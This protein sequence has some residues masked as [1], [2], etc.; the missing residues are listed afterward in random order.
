VL[1]LALLLGACGDDDAPVDASIPADAGVDAGPDECADFVVPARPDTSACAD[2][3]PDADPTALVACAYGSGHA[4][5]WSIDGAGLPAYDFAI[6]ERCD[7]AGRA[8]SPRPR[9]QRD[10]VHL[11]GNGR[12]LM[13]MARASGAV[14]LYSQDRGHKWFN[15]LD[16]WRDPMTPS[17]P[18]QLGGGFSYLALPD[19]TV[20][21]TRFEDLPLGRATTLQTRRFGVG[22]VE[23]VTMLGALRVTR[24]VLAPDADA[25][26]LVAELRVENTGGSE[27]AVGLVELWD[28]NRDD[29]SVELATSD[30]LARTITDGLERRRRAYTA[31]Y[32]ESLSYDAAARVAV[33]RATAK[34]LP[35]GIDDRLDP[36]PR[37]WFPDPLYLAALDEGVTPDAVW[38]DDRELWDGDDRSP[39]AR[40]ATAGDAATRTLALDGNGQH[41]VLA[42][43]VPLTVAGGAT[44]VRR[45]AFGY[46]PGGGTPDA[47][48]TELRARA[49]TLAADTDASWRS[50]L[51]YAS[52]PGLPHAGAVQ[53]ELAWAAYNTLAS[54][55][56]DEVHQ[57][58]V[59]G[60]G[61]AYRYIHGLDGAMGDL[62]LFADAI[63]L[64]D[65]ALA[66]D[67]LVY[68]MST[69]QAGATA[70]PWRFPYAT[71]GVGSYSDVGIYDQRTD[72]YWL[73][74]SGLG[75]YVGL[76]RDR[77]VLDRVVPYWPSALGE[78][79]DVV[80]HVAHGL[81]WAE[82]LGYGARGLVALGTNDYA[83]GVASL[84]TERATP[85]GTSSTYNAGFIVNGFPLAADV[86]EA[87]DAA[88]ATRLRSIEAGQRAI[89]GGDAWLGSFYARGF[90]DSGN[91]LAPG[92]L[93]LEPQML[94]ILGGIADGARAD[95]LLALTADKL[96]T[97][98]GAMSTVALDPIDPV[99]GPDQPQIAGVWPVANAWTTEAYAQRDAAAGW[100]SFTRNTLFTHAALYPGLWYGVWTGP[101]SFFGPDAARPGEADA[102]KATALT[103]Y[104]A[105]NAH[106]HTSPLRALVGLLGIRGTRD[107]IAIAPHLPTETFHV[108]FP[109]LSLRSTPTR[110]DGTYTPVGAGDVVLR[111]RLTTALAAAAALR[112]Q[113]DGADVACARDG[114]DVV[115]TAL[116]AAETRLVWSVE[117]AP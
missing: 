42:M 72:A 41:G 116:A 24:R 37:D 40:A 12:G 56:Y 77:A 27:S 94:A 91:P 101:D 22:Y 87:R 83:D 48:V 53:R 93:F 23:T 85:A 81:D 113:V 5:A 21:S 62:C 90:V 108:V 9:V 30:L 79:G 7:P 45:F 98:L 74:P 46:V 19:G 51:V 106:M 100:D 32:T 57:T 33:L 8:Y 95:A 16:T 73:L 112:V 36:S 115:F 68:V 99:G 20:G 4:G 44:V 60:Q 54:A 67:T 49:S 11:I 47:A 50:R 80:E 29:L 2:L 13:A 65:P 69:Q 107:G 17:F 86:L 88:L 38:L 15:R 66:R 18:P 97:P 109:R 39:P 76:T 114:A 14:E 10:P 59:V 89:Y 71:T 103:D 26:A 61:G 92:L 3:A 43:R 1:G 84:S 58:R 28:P 55:S 96:E 78:S 31:D 52:F 6:D 110:L 63:G 35:A 25:R 105:L 111:V 117:A 102:H 82:A 70:T 34:S 75:R 104:P 64:V